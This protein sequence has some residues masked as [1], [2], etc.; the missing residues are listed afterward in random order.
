MIL[1]EELDCVI[2]SAYIPF[3]ARKNEDGSANIIFYLG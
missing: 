1:V 2:C 3:R